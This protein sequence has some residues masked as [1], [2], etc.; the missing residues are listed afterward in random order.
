MI[1]S[2]GR[3]ETDMF[4]EVYI[5]IELPDGKFCNEKGITC[6][7]FSW[8][9]FEPFCCIFQKE[10]LMSEATY[11]SKRLAECLQLDDRICINCGEFGDNWC[12]LHKEKRYTTE[13]CENFVYWSWK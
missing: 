13:T 9:D 5:K 2:I 4:H 7:Y 6:K 3:E 1:V 8:T 11:K 12:E 10:V